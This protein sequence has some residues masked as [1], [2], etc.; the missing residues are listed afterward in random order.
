M[1]APVVGSADN[2]SMAERFF[3]GRG[4]EAVNIAFLHTVIFCIEFT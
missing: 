3:T 2:D 1:Y 4:K